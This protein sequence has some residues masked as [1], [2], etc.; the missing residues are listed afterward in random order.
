MNRFTIAFIC[1]LSG[2]WMTIMF[3]RIDYTKGFIPT[4]IVVDAF[5]VR[6]VN[7][8]CDG[9]II[10]ADDGS[11]EFI[12]RKDYEKAVSKIKKHIER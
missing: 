1:Y 6:T 9:Q 12:T 8:T 4:D 3:Y 10:T 7:T 11:T 2:V 5:I